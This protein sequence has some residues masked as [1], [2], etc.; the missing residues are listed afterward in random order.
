MVCARPTGTP[1][2]ISSPSPPLPPAA[3]PF[4]CSS[5]EHTY[6]IYF[7]SS[8]AVAGFSSRTH[9]LKP[10]LSTVPSPARRISRPLRHHTIT[11]SSAPSPPHLGSAP[12]RVRS[13]IHSSQ[14]PFKSKTKFIVSKRNLEH[15]RRLN[16]RARHDPA[17]AICCVRT[18]CVH[19]ARRRTSFRGGGVMG[20]SY[21]RVRHPW[22]WKQ[23]N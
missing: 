21:E 3:C 4:S 22:Q 13:P 2:L 23:D 10:P 9:T 1:L 12:P 7:L 5:A 18:E 19:C 14:R 20:T 17:G 6:F 11:N 8:V 15:V 16:K